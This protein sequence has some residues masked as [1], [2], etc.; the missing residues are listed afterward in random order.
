V[1]AAPLDPG[2]T[3]QRNHLVRW[4]AVQRLYGGRLGSTRT[5]V[6]ERRAN[7]AKVAAARKLLTLVYWGCATGTSVACSPGRREPQPGAARTRGRCWSD[8][9]YGGV[10]NRF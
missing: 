4:A 8:P 2:G 10:V 7:I 1:R 9:H 6:A 3:K 5:R